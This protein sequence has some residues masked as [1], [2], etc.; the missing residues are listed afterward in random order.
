MVLAAR[1]RNFGGTAAATVPARQRKHSSSSRLAVESLGSVECQQQ[2]RAAGASGQQLPSLAAVACWALAPV[3]LIATTLRARARA[4]PELGQQW[5]SAA[6]RSFTFGVVGCA[7]GVGAA[8]PSAQAR[9][10]ARNR[11]WRGLITCETSYK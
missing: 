8:P 10:A 5:S 1:R 4:C 6:V 2:G 3:T 9:A 7:S 11:P